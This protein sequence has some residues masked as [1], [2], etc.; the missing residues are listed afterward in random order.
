MIDIE[1]VEDG[2]I[3]PELIDAIETMQAETIMDAVANQYAEMSDDDVIVF[4]ETME[5]TMVLCIKKRIEAQN[6][7]G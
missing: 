2:T 5:R 3:S 1:T 6:A 7:D 4:H